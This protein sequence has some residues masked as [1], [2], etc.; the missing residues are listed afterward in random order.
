MRFGMPKILVHGW[1][2]HGVAALREGGCDS[3][4]VVTGAARPP[5][6]DGSTEIH[7]E[8]WA[9]GIGASLYCGLTRIGEGPHRVVIHLIDYPDISSAVVQRVLQSGGDHLARA[10]FNGRP[11]HPVNVPRRHLTPLADTLINEDGAGPYLRAHS[12]V[13]VEC[14]DL[15]TGRDADTQEAARQFDRGL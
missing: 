11:G 6:P 3:V 5:L 15:A 10:V 2:S 8:N 9:W 4:H 13:A 12:V 1:L 14:G 7:C